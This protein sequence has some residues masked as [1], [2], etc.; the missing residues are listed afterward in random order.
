MARI[1]LTITDIQGGV[2]IRWKGLPCP[3]HD[4][5]LELF[6]AAERFAFEQYRKQNAAHMTLGEFLQHAKTNCPE[7]G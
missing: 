6:T 1:T 5:P 4:K 7:H 2:Q 3:V